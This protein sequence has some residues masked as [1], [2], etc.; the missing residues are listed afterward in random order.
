ML[1]AKNK[2]TG[3]IV[4][5]TLKQ[6]SKCLTMKNIEQGD[7][8][9]RCNN[10]VTTNTNEISS[11]LADN[12]SDEE[13][14]IRDV[15]SVVP[16][17]KSEVRRRLND[18]IRDT[19][20]LPMGVSQWLNHG[21]KYGYDTFFIKKAKQEERDRIIK[22]IKDNKLHLGYANNIIEEINSI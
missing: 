13:E 15:C 8:C 20:D 4:E 16:K 7:I 22:I 3:E 21:I 14:F 18:I 10:V 2:T 1:K 12:Q 17:S 19:K 9:D 6:C 5:N 11:K